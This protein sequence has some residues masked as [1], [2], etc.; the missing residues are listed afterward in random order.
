[1]MEMFLMLSLVI[2]IVFLVLGLTLKGSALTIF[3][4]LVA[5]QTLIV[6]IVQFQNYW[7]APKR[8]PA[9][10]DAKELPE[11][12]R[13]AFEQLLALG[14]HRIG[15][16]EAKLDNKRYPIWVLV[17]SAGTTCIE[18]TVLGKKINVEF[19]SI[20]PDKAYAET[21]YV[22]YYPTLPRVD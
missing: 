21:F 7:Q 5:A 22:T 1:M 6:A 15:D 12:A 16:A 17:D 8:V 2:F 10:V 18:I 4:L 3:L 19:N 9:P 20:F 13:P 11:I 14:F